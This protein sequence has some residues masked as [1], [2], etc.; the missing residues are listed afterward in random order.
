MKPH[1]PRL[2]RRRRRPRH[3]ITR[4]RSCRRRG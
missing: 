4:F 1:P 2:L 3:R